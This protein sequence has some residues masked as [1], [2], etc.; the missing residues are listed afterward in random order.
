MQHICALAATSVEGGRERV[1]NSFLLY[2]GL[3]RVCQVDHTTEA[4]AAKE[5]ACLQAGELDSA[6]CFYMRYHF[7]GRR[8]QEFVNKNIV[9][10]TVCA[11]NIAKYAMIVENRCCSEQQQL[12]LLHH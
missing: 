6:L 3:V 8:K 10:Q 4:K 5:T 2:V 12:L 7:C 9:Y 1:S 11:T